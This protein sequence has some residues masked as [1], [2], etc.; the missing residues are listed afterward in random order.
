M[1]KTFLRRHCP[2][3]L[4]IG[5]SRRGVKTSVLL[6]TLL[7]VGCSTLEP[8]FLQPPLG[9]M[10]KEAAPSSQMLAEEPSTRPTTTSFYQTPKPPTGSRAAA[11][12]VPPPPSPPTTG[13]GR[14]ASVNLD[15]MPLPQFVMAVFGA[16]LK[17]NVSMDPQVAQRT[18]MVSLRTGK[19]QTDEQIF[20]AAQAVLR[21]YGL[22]VSDF[23][24]LVRVVPETGQSGYLPEIRRGRAQPDVPAGLRPIFYLVELE[25]TTPGQVSNW[26]RTLFPGRLTAVD[27]AMRN[28]ILLSGQSDTVMAALEAIQ[29]LDQPM[30]RGRLSAR[31]AP[32]FWS[33]DELAKRLVEMLNAEGYSASQS[34]LAQTPIL[35]LPIGP[36]NS[37][38]VFA[39]SR[40]VLDHVLRW[41]QELD[42]SP[43]GRGGGFINY[44]V[45]NTDAAALAAT[46]KEVMGESVT[47]AAAP[48][49]VAGGAAPVTV[50]GGSR[51][52]VNKAANSLIIKTTSTEYQQ[53]YGLI[54]ELDRPSRGALIMATVAEVRLTDNEQFG[55]QWMLKQFQSNGYLVNVGT[56]SRPGTSA[57]V[58]DGTF[59]VALATL[60]GDA[61]VLLTALAS[62]N[63]IRILSN[64]SVM[65]RNGEAA[66]I[67]VGQE[68]PILTSQISNA[69]TGTGIGTGIQQTIQYRSTGVILKVKPVVHAGGRIDIDVAQEVSAAQQNDTGVNTSPI[70]LTRKVDTKLSISDG[71]TILLGGLIQEQQTKGNSGIPYLKDIPYLG[72]V[73]RSSMSENTER[74]ELVILLT[75]Y[76]VDDDFDAQAVTEAFRN[77]FAWAREVQVPGAADKAAAG[78][79]LPAAGAASAQTPYGSASQPA[80]QSSTST[81]SGK[82]LAA[83]D[84]SGAGAPSEGAQ[85]ADAGQQPVAP[86]ANK[87][88][89]ESSSARSSTPRVPDASTAEAQN[90]YRSRPY[91]LPEK[92][93]PPSTPAASVAPLQQ[94][95]AFAPPI[96]APGATSPGTPV[97]DSTPANV[98]PKP[99]SGPRP[100]TDEALKQEL[101]KAIQGGGSDVKR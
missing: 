38:V 30:M 99:V 60:A 15:S 27:D 31:I 23:N 63:K 55:F 41:A 56:S 28:S 29:L 3:T 46:L 25:S 96:G 54:Q 76:V 95:D 93:G 88:G 84:T 61:R 71:H 40:E 4:K 70:I 32:V 43:P 57:S 10:P 44:Y 17:R 14:V 35:V 13:D 20:A 9:K 81:A 1:N 69:N 68:V 58:A 2:S 86:T 83:P 33:A 6:A 78:K 50:S 7:S 75:P 39:A 45:R 92:D 34:A 49:P 42:Q 72:A 91:V 59:R 21:S 48:A 52:V 64:P 8:P 16:I 12:S 26:L 37:V 24:G 79:P 101:L 53:L 65:A 85:P 74:T 90:R 97:I 100:V 5:V 47:A 94:P 51:V 66:T 82:A 73:F 87:A 80:A 11:G 77:Q 89:E 62:T 22:A 19:P 36:V 98:S 67:Q 18:D